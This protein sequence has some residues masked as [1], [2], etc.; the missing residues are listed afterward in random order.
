MD[1]RC[2]GPAAELGCKTYLPKEADVRPVQD[3]LEWT[4]LF[5]LAAN[6]LLKPLELGLLAVTHESRDHG[7]QLAPLFCRRVDGA[8]LRGEGYG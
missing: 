2:E 3:I 4:L 6:P 1:M 5:E 7:D 8:Q